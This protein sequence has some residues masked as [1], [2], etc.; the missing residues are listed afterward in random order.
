M[1]I[2]IKDVIST[3]ELLISGCVLTL[4][5]PIISIMFGISRRYLIFMILIIS[6]IV[7]PPDVMSLLMLSLPIILI[8][9][10]SL[11]I[12]ILIKD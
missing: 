3:I 6:S 7:T 11:F 4:V 12:Y 1:Q 5:L 2:R 10:S 9:E 8:V